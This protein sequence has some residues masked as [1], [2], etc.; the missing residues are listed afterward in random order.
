MVSHILVEITDPSKDADA[1]KRIDALYADLKANKRSFEDIAKTDSDDKT[2]AEKN[3]SLGSVVAGDWGPEFEKAV[4]ALK[5]GE[6]SEPVKTESGYEIIR[7]TE[8]KPA[9]DKT[10]E[11]AKA[12]V[13]ADYRKDQ[14]DKAF[15]EK[16]DEIQKLAYENEGALDPV[17]AAVGLT[18]QQSDWI[19]ANQGAGI[20][21]NAKVRAAAF[22]DDVKAGKNS[23]LLE[24]SE[25]EAVVLRVVNHE[26]AKQKP[27]ADVQDTIRQTLV[28]QK[29]RE[30]VAQ[31]GEAA[32]KAVIAKQ[33]WAGLVDAGVGSETNV[34]KLGF[35]GRQDSSK[36]A[37]E[38]LD[39]AFAAAQ[40]ASGKVSWAGIG[41]ANGDYVVIG[42]NAVKAGDSKLAADA[43]D[44]ASQGTAMRELAAM[45][46]GW[47]ETAKIEMHPENL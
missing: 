30:L 1:K 24:V 39:K 20:A 6:T 22:S 15:S 19:S 41:L 8:I 18:V 45:L 3:G 5:A 11:Q 25:T 33:S 7:V 12:E 34:Q 4:F 36:L 35:I 28:A 14:A 13:E 43:N 32:L 21:M 42:V 17:A 23:D 9:V 40:P 16:A 38:A 31:K 29:S 37:T 26:D 2:A 47:R 44:T 27:L 10:F 46:E